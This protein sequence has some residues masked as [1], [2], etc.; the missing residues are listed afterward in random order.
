M[1]NWIC[2]H[3][4]KQIRFWIALCSDCKNKKRYYTAIISQNKK[5]LK[6]LLL[7]S[8]LSLEWFDKFILYS[9]NIITFWKLLVEFKEKDT[10]RSL[11]RIK[12]SWIISIIFIIACTVCYL[13]LKPC[14]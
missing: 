9:N 3:C 7:E 5:K 8:K 14:F 1:N 6:K 12:T 11:E 4:G 13:E 2:H 10:K